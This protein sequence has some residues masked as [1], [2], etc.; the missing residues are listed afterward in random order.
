MDDATLESR[1]SRVRQLEQHGEDVKI[2]K[3][4]PFV[5]DRRIKILLRGI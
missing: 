3:V 5:G 1:D 4:A 2:V